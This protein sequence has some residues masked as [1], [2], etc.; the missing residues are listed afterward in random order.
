MRE[1]ET[2][3]SAFRTVDAALGVSEKVGGHMLADLSHHKER[4]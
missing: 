3:S 1:S 4:K 2:Y